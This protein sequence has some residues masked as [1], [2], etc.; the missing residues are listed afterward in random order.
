MWKNT[1]AVFIGKRS[2]IFLLALIFSAAA[3][4][5][6]KKTGAYAVYYNVSLRK[7]PVY[8]VEREDK[9]IAISFDCA[10]GAEKTDELLRVTKEYGVKCTFFVTQFWAEKYPGYVEKIRS[11]GHDIGTHGAT[12]SYMSKLSEDKIVNELETSCAAIEKITGEKVILF[13]PPYGDYNDR[14]I[15]TC[16]KGGLYAIQWDVDSLDWKN[17]SARD[18]AS[19]V[20]S[21]VKS[22]SI[23]L[24][25]NNAEN[26]PEALPEIF[27]NL[28]GRGYEFVKIS[29]LIYMENYTVDADGRQRPAEKT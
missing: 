19:R 26:T 28:Q 2:A 15:K 22:G 25:H 8:S 4:V 16:E 6:L 10:W 27:A 29:E 21:R 13:R 5:T 11:A 14:L 17:V 9:K 7:L 3:C 20:I 18:I 1:V 12:H 24:C 23:I